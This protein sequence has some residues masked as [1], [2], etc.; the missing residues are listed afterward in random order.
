MSNKKNTTV[1]AEGRTVTT[2]SPYDRFRDDDGNSLELDYS[3]DNRMTTK[4]RVELRLECLRLAMTTL[5]TVETTKVFPFAKKL[6]KFA[7][8]EE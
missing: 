7:T 1:F 2:S 5:D 4:E 3:G 8:R 6:W